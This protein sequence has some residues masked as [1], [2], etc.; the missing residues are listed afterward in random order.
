M[1]TNDEI[2]GIFM[3]QLRKP[4]QAYLRDSKRYHSIDATPI[5]YSKCGFSQRWAVLNHFD[6]LPTHHW[7]KMMNLDNGKVPNDG[8]RLSEAVLMH[9]VLCGV[10]IISFCIPK[11]ISW[12]S[13]MIFVVNSS[14]KIVQGLF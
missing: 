9:P 8:S 13:G 10:E 11:Y 5:L 14:G 1:T 3:G 2:E 12:E 6:S 7:H 4:L